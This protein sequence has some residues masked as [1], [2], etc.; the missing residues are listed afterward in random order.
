MGDPGF[1]K[2]EGR[3]FKYRD[4]APGLKKSLSGGGGGGGTPTHFCFCLLRHLHYG[5]GVPSACQTDLRGEKPKKGGG[6]DLP[7]PPRSATAIFNQQELCI[8]KKYTF[9]ASIISGWTILFACM[10]YNSK[11]ETFRSSDKSYWDHYIVHSS[12]KFEQARN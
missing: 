3:E 11:R 8:L 10:V 9:Y 2:R 7:L 4:A 6:E 1:V 12:R 5:V